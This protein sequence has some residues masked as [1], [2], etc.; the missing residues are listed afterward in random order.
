IHK[1]LFYLY[2]LAFLQCALSIG[3]TV[4]AA[5]PYQNT[6]AAIQ[7]TLF[8]KGLIFKNVHGF[9]SPSEFF[10]WT[11]SSTMWEYPLAYIFSLMLQLFFRS[12]S[13]SCCITKIKWS[14]Q[15]ILYWIR[16]NF[17]NSTVFWQESSRHCSPRQCFF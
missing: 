4:K 10:L 8:I 3:R 2:I 5:I 12:C 17:C 6:V 16:C 9:S 13:S 7:G 1:T 15:S 14:K 11:C